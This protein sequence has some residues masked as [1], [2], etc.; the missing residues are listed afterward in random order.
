MKYFKTQGVY[1]ASNVWFNPSEM[2]AKSYNWWIFV[3][4]INGKIYFNNHAYSNSTRKHQSKVRD[5]LQ[6]LGIK[7]TTVNF[8]E[9]LAEVN[10]ASDIKHLELKQRIMEAARLESNR[11]RRNAKA[12][13]LRAEKKEA[14]AIAPLAASDAQYVLNKAIELLNERLGDK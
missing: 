4:K 6:D 7:Y 3:R 10:S 12:R 14:L 5:V 8:R 9:S 13:R 1:K 11:V 2:V